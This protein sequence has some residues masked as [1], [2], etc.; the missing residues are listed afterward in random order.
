MGEVLR[1]LEMT[2]NGRTSTLDSSGLGTQDYVLVDDHGRAKLGRGDA[3]HLTYAEAWN[4][5]GDDQ[6]RRERV[7][8]EAKSTLEH[9]L[10][11]HADMTVTEPKDARDK[12]IIKEGRGFHARDVANTM[13]C[14]ITDVW[15]AR[16]AAGC[17]IEFGEP[18]PTG[19]K[20]KLSIPERNAEV[21]RLTGLGLSQ[22]A[23]ATRLDIGHKSVRYVLARQK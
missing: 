4:A 14:G 18:R 23:V 3:P 16:L 20:R 8:E 22:R 1:G 19:P 9:I 5:A 6:H 17:D 15:K 10:K 21:C 12:R 13:R 11:S 2:S 7:F